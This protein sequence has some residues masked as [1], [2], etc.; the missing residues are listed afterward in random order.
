[1]RIIYKLASMKFKIETFIIALFVLLFATSCKQTNKTPYPTTDNVVLLT[2]ENMPAVEYF[3]L[4]K[5]DL[6]EKYADDS[7]YVYNDSVVIIVDS[8]HPDPFIVTLFNLNTKEE[9]AGYFKKGNGPNEMISVMAKRHRNYLH[10]IDLGTHAASRLNIDSALTKGFDYK[11][12]IIDLECPL[13]DDF[14]YSGQDTIIMVNQMYINDGYGVSNLPEFIKYDAKTGDLLN[15]Y[16]RNEV[17]M[18]ANMIQRSIVN[19][20]NKYAVLWGTLPII[21]IYDQN[22]NLVKLY[23]DSKYKDPD[24]L[25]YDEGLPMLAVDGFS[26]FFS[27]NCQTD[28]YFFAQ[29]IRHQMTGTEFGRKGGIKW[30][31]SEDARF[32][33]YKDTE[34]WCFNN[35]AELVRRFKS[36]ENIILHRSSYNEKTGK[37]Y[38][39]A[40]DK[41]EETNL[42]LC[43][44]DK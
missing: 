39:E 31:S 37:L 28:N 6:P 15:D 36:R 42:Y 38:V 8:E 26:L 41:D 4:E 23:R 18:P 27:L 24:I 44:F 25:V 10:L 22:L 11:P 30:L 35:N 20:G 32:G 19:L 16:K 40:K 33:R 13:I 1:M 12:V 21:T 34:I 43:V 17:N 2:D 14:V 29:N 9:I 5:I 7:Y 3:T